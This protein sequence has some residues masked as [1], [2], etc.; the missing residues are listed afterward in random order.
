VPLLRFLNY[1]NI[2]GIKALLALSGAALL[3]YQALPHFSPSSPAGRYVRA[4]LTIIGIVSALAWFNLGA[5]HFNGGFFHFHEFFHYYLG[6]KYSAELGYTR[7]YECV[8]VVDVEQGRAVDVASD[9]ITD[10]TNNELQKGSPAIADPDLCKRHFAS[11]ARWD[12]FTHDVEWFHARLSNQK[13]HDLKKDHGYN[14]TPVWNIAGH[15]LANTGPISERQMTMLALIDPILL[16][17]MLGLIYWAFGW[18]V[19]C[20]AAI[21][22]G[23][24]Y[25][26]R[27]TFIGGAFL[28]EDWLALTVAS[29]CLARRGRAAL[30]GFALG[31]AALLRIF[32]AFAACG[33]VLHAAVNLVRGRSIE[34]AHVK[35]AAGVLAALA[36]LVPVS[37][38]VGHERPG[39]TAWREFAANSRKHLSTPLTNNVGLPMLLSTSANS[40]AANVRELWMDSPWDVWK[41][42]RRQTFEERR[43][44]YYAIVGAFLA[45]LGYACSQ[46]EDWIALALGVGAIPFL[47]DLT[48]YY[49]GFLLVFATLWPRHRTIGIALCVA[50]ALTCLTPAI[51]R[52]DDDRHVVI[53]AIIVLLCI[54]VTAV[55]ARRQKQEVAAAALGAAASAAT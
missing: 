20:I 43:P 42:E 39:V 2:I 19:T 5:F 45:L 15:V 49:Y 25:P 47:T 29:V 36:L 4:G 7:L 1:E 12:E 8:A 34:R 13:W 26:A 44:L 16:G 52:E 11:K 3:A 21:W 31:W 14:A 27:Y 10:L 33:L 48:S 46:H 38:F 22:W 40:R 41:E 32:P 17:A 50:S 54:F 28:R 6:S 23:T 9:W 55:C 30:S 35:F 24:N 18:E 37:M 51:I 53:S